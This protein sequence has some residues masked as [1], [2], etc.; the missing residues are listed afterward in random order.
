MFEKIFGIDQKQKAKILG[1][2]DCGAV[3]YLGGH[4]GLPLSVLSE[5]YFYEDRFELE[6]NRISV[7]YSKIRDIT[8]SNEQERC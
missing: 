2:I 5:M 7:Y 3:R 8:N 4:K 1:A 6:A